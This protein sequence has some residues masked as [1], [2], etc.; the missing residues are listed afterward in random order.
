MNPAQAAERSKPENAGGN[1]KRGI[2]RGPRGGNA[3]SA[4]WWPGSRR[5]PRPDRLF[6]C[7]RASRAAA[8]PMKGRGL[9]RAGEVALAN[10]GSFAIPIVGRGRGAGQ[11]VIGDECARAS[12]RPTPER[13]VRMG[14]GFPE[15]D[16]QG[17]TARER[18][19]EARNSGGREVGD[20]LR[21]V[22]S[23]CACPA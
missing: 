5:P 11:L 23:A 10:S 6:A 21:S 9:V 17:S 2:S 16:G 4:C 15:E 7:A 1:A 13:M 22:P 20:H 18:G 19:H 14:I 3:W 8:V 12:N